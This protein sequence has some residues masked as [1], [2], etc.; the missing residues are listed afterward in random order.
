MTKVETERRFRQKDG[1]WLI[2]HLAQRSENG[3]LGWL[4]VK[5]QLPGRSEALR[6]DGGL[7]TGA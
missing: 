5:S 2:L 7:G 1:D 3:E 6:A 4:E